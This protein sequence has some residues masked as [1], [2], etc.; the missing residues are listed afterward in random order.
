MPTTQ[1]PKVIFGSNPFFG[2][3]RDTH[4]KWLDFLQENGIETIDTAQVYAESEVNL[5][6][7]NAPSRFTVDTKAAA[8]FGKPATKDVILKS[9][10][11]SLKKLNTQSVDIYYLHT[12]DRRVSLEETLEGVNELYK[13]GAFK[14][15]GISNFLAHEIEE[16]VRITKERGWV[17][18]SVYQGNYSAIARRTETE[19]LPVLRKHRIIFYAYSPIAGGF[20]A[21][22]KETLTSTQ[23]WDPESAL[24]KLYIALYHRPSYLKALNTWGQIAKDERISQSELAYR[25]AVHN[26]SL[27]GDLG[28][29]I[30][31]GASKIDHFRETLN[32]I[33]KGPLSSD[34]AKR[35]DEIW[36][37]IKDE[38]PLN[39]AGDL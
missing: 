35:I 31:I 7:I 15:F 39:N 25:W 4:E 8:G 27:R 23:R 6:N 34:T 32:W 37:S 11:E 36:E 19:I 21:K 29:A 18:P 38:A 2:G 5:G 13:E 16:V 28:D 24:G 9:G 20:L 10:H 30:I 1:P 3:D 33:K 14:R 22:T 12:P 26:S 17:R